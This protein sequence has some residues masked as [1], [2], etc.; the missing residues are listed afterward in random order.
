MFSPTD[1]EY[2]N[3]N[4]NISLHSSGASLS[5]YLNIDPSYLNQDGGAEFVFSTD[6][7]KKE[8]GVKECSPALNVIHV[9][10]DSWRNLGLIEGLRSPDGK[11]MKLRVNSVLNG[12]VA[13]MYCSVNTAIEK[14]RGKEDVYNSVAAAI[15]MEQYSNQ[16]VESVQS[17]WLACLV[18]AL[19]SCIFRGQTW[20]SS[21]PNWA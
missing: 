18:V 10:F 19:Q 13:L 9:R 15:T 16:R 12:V 17:A 2:D 3:S 6:S 5:P 4:L 7:Q 21:T 1:K 20:S 14:A 8:D 11:T